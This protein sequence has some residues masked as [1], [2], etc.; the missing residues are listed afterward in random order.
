MIP[1]DTGD[2]DRGAAQGRRGDVRAEALRPRDRRAPE[3]RRAD[4][5]A[6]RAPRRPRRAPRRRRRARRGGRHAAWASTA[7]SSRTCATPPSLHDIGKVAIPDAIIT[8][9]GPLTDEEWEF[10]RRHT[11][12]GERILAAAPA[13]GARRA[14]RPLLTRSLGR[15]RL[16]RRARRRRDPA[17]RTDH[18]RLRLLR[19]DDLQPPLRAGQGRST[20]RSPSSAA[21]P[22]RSSTPTIVPVFEQVLADRAKPPT[23][24]AT[25]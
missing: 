16:P 14:T 22:E 5:R 13:L 15:Q 20:T 4:A 3:Q 9:P 11:L 18:R 8:K 6:R 24:G 17:R 25:A 7:R 21:A 1:Q 12:I 10:M 2:A 19:R 23:A